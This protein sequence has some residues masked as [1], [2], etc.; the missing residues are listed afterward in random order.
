MMRKRTLIAFILVVG[1]LCSLLGGCGKDTDESGNA[2]QANEGSI[3]V[4]EDGGNGSS[5]QEDLTIN[6]NDYLIC[7]VVGDGGGKFLPET[8]IDI[9]KFCEENKNK[10]AD[11][12]T[13]GNL[14]A[15]AEDV[16]YNWEGLELKS[17]CEPQPR[18]RNWIEAG[19]TV[20]F[21]WNLDQ[22]KMAELKRIM[23]PGI[24]FVYEDFAVTYYNWELKEG[25]KLAGYLDFDPD[26]AAV[27]ME[28][29]AQDGLC[30]GDYYIIRESGTDG[31]GYLSTEL[32]VSRFA[33]ACSHFLAEGY[34]VADV[35]NVVDVPNVR[36]Q[37]KSGV[38]YDSSGAV[39]DLSNGD[40]VDIA[41]E[42][43]ERTYQGKTLDDMLTV[44]FLD[45]ELT[46]TMD[47]LYEVKPVDLFQHMEYSLKGMGDLLNALS[48]DAYVKLPTG[49]NVVLSAFA[50][51]EDKSAIQVG[52]TLTVDFKRDAE[53]Y[54]EKYGEGL[55]E[56]TVTQITVEKT[57]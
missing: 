16:S 14:E 44:P 32:D 20:A 42:L 37:C 13:A 9:E 26:P 55:F 24:T 17:C 34:T 23:M 53:R 36:Y 19:D 25:T 50:Y 21:K 54:M 30:I 2:T 10:M 56:N 28:K 48:V 7:G 18:D 40:S 12:Y 27:D 33:Q 4:T 22:E 31:K 38:S 51:K 49:E 29:I 45:M 46:Y 5:G 35:L 8:Y 47:K 57:K 11:Y 52:D 39:H 43:K 1:V 41:T 3:P 15:C 6:L